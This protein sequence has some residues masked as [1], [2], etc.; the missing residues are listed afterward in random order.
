MTDKKPRWENENFSPDGGVPADI[1]CR[2]CMFRKP[3][4]EVGGEIRERYTHGDCKMFEPPNWKPNE[5]LWE[6]AQCEYYEKG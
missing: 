4:V 1:V 3:A 6:H 2:T 5:I